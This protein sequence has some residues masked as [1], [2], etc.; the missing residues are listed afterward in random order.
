MEIFGRLQTNS[1]LYDCVFTQG[2]ALF[3]TMSEFSGRFDY[4]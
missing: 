3:L 1:L 4:F 2:L